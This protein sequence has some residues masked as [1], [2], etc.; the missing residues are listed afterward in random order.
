MNS[1]SRHL[2]LRVEIKALIL[3]YELLPFTGNKARQLPNCAKREGG[4]F[5]SEKI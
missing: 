4:H 5:L 3:Q 1:S 2:T